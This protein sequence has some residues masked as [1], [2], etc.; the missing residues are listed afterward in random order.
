MADR[1]IGYWGNGLQ[2]VPE[3][4]ILLKERKLTVSESGWVGP[5]PHGLL[6]TAGLQGAPLAAT[7]CFGAPCVGAQGGLQELGIT[8]SA[9]RK[10]TEATR[11][12]PPTDVVTES[13]KTRAGPAAPIIRHLI[14][15]ACPG[16]GSG[17]SHLPAG[18]G[19]SRQPRAEVRDR[20]PVRPPLCRSPHLSPVPTGQPAALISGTR[21]WPLASQWTDGRRGRTEQK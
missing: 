13:H 4:V 9:Q 1:I 3:I 11:D 17:T 14:S 20:L 5:H 12:P 8:I 19:S 21:G 10:Q 15:H 6:G 16:L 7:S 2:N 18:T